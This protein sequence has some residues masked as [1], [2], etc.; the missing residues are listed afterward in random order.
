M[1]IPTHLTKT[2][3]YYDV[4]FTKGNEDVEDVD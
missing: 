4:L 1:K 3:P 2:L